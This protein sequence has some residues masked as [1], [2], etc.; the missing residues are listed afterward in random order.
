MA[1]PS[2]NIVIEGGT[3]FS[4]NFKLKKN[5]E[6]I[7]LTGYTCTSKMKKHYGASTYYSFITSLSTPL[8]SGIITISMSSS[9][10]ST[11]PPGRYVY[12]VLISLSGTVIKVI[13]GTVIVKGT[14]SK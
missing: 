9:T 11:I 8:T 7:D 1:I 14:A 2:V 4:T 12:D 6:P 10:T 3:S 13:E 5:G